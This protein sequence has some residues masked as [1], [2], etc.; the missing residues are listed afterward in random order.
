MNLKQ[1]SLVCLVATALACTAQQTSHSDRGLDPA[2]LPL[3]KGAPLNVWL[4]HTIFPAPV[5]VS[6][7]D[8]G[9]HEQTAG[10]FGR[11]ASAAGN[12]SSDT[13]TTAGSFGEASSNAGQTAG[14]Y[15]QTAGAFGQPSSTYGQT[16]GSYGTP[17]GDIPAGPGSTSEAAGNYNRAPSRA[18]AWP[19]LTNPALAHAPVNRALLRDPLL[20]QV[21]G[22]RADLGSARINFIDIDPSELVK[23]LASTEGTPDF[24]DVLVGNP[25]PQEWSSSGVAD[26]YGIAMLGTSG[27]AEPGESSLL[28]PNS[29]LETAILRRGA[30]RLAAEA[31][32]IWVR[33]PWLGVESSHPYR[34]PSMTEAIDLASSTAA[35]ILAKGQVGGAADEALAK[36]TPPRAMLHSLQPPLNAYSYGASVR[37]D[38]VDAEANDRLAVVALRCIVTSPA[39]FGV[40]HPLVVMRRGQDKH[41]KVLQISPD[42]TPQLLDATFDA[43]EPFATPVKPGQVT[44]VGGITQAAPADGD[45]RP[46]FPD[47]WWDN[48]GGAGLLV[49]EW[50]EK[51][52]TYGRSDEWRPSHMDMLPDNDQRLKIRVPATFASQIQTYR[53]RVWSVGL[54]GVMKISPWRTLNI[55]S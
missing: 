15:G 17:S 7:P 36:F 10:D 20:A 52:R 40:A 8:L 2:L 4:I 38:V 54:G 3:G 12:V 28:E 25:L 51:D 43:L 14:S 30:N 5:V 9:Y 23:Q 21:P 44:E 42:L 55:V 27:I 16:A 31:F 46:T 24:P 19:G 53:W 49:L 13:G 45:N 37:T 26:R 41:W 50:Q 39:G 32:V 34:N 11:T 22:I 18:I 6:Q 47:L 1:S 48:G 29:V 33:D 35:S